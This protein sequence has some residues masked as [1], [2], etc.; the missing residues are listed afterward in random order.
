MF[1]QQSRKTNDR[2]N[3][4]ADAN[5]RLCNIGIK[6]S[7]SWAENKCMSTFVRIY[8]LIVWN[9]NFG[10]TGSSFIRTRTL[11]PE[12]SP[13][14]LP[15][16]QRKKK[17]GFDLSSWGLKPQCIQN[18]YKMFLQQTEKKNFWVNSREDSNL[19]LCKIGVKCSTSWAVKINCKSTFYMKLYVNKV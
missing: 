7:T 3:S 4:R 10:Q 6:Y 11:D 2:V 19:R 13:S 15:A 8:T 17:S 18:L 5:L 9:E 1:L 16:G 14:A 12:T